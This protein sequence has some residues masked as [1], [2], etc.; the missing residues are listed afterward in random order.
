MGK[1]KSRSLLCIVTITGRAF[2]ERTVVRVACNTDFG[3]VSPNMRRTT[4]A[5]VCWSNDW[6]TLRPSVFKASSKLSFTSPVNG[7]ES[8]GNITQHMEIP[9]VYDINSAVFSLDRKICSNHVLGLPTSF[10]PHT[11]A[12]NLT[13]VYKLHVLPYDKSS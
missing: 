4:L 3:R 11:L 5:I 6:S 12:H 10:H 13:F 2:G 1:P 8:T 9:S 7:E